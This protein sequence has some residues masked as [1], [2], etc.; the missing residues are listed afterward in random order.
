MPNHPADGSSG[1]RDAG[2]DP[3]AVLGKLVSIAS[4]QTAIQLDAFSA[5]LLG[6][7]AGFADRPPS[8]A[9]R[10][11]CGRAARHLGGSRMTFH[12]L[13]ASCLNEL[14]AQECDLSARRQQ[15]GPECNA[16]DLSLVTFEAMEQ[17]VLIDNLGH[18]LAAANAEALD[19]LS[20][21]ISHLMQRQDASLALNPFRP[22]VFLEAV[23]D[24]WTRFDLNG[25]SPL[26]I[27][28]QMR[29]EIFLD[30]EPILRALNSAL[31]GQGILPTLS[32]AYRLKKSE[33]A[34]AKAAAS[35]RRHLPLYSKLNNWLS[36]AGAGAAHPG[37]GNG[38][39]AVHPGL[40][41]LLDR[42]QKQA[43]A[44]GS[45]MQARAA[46]A[47]ILRQVREQALPGTL[48]QADANALDLLAKTLDHIFRE[49]CIPAEVKLLMSRLQIPLLK[50]ALS[51]RDFFFQEDHPARR[52]IDTVARTSVACDREQGS[53]D[54]LFRMI[55]Q[56]VER[57][58]QEYDRQ[59]G[60][61]DAVI[62]E[63][64]S[65][66][67]Q[68]A[69]ASGDALAGIIAEATRHEKIIRAKE[70]AEKDVA[71]RIESGEAAGF[72][73]A[74]LETQW[75]RVLGLAHS[76]EDT[77][78]EALANAL[79]T[80]DDLVWSAQPKAAP[81]ERKELLGRLPSL[82]ARLNSWLNVVKWEGPDRVKFFS[83]LAERHA[84]IVRT[85]AQ[86]S[87][88]AQLEITMNVAQKASER[89]LRK[90]A[91]ELPEQA[92]DEFVHYVDGLETG[93]WIE[94]ARNHGAREKSRLA[95][96]S[97]RRSRFAFT[98]RQGLEPFALTFDELA[99]AFRQQ[100]A[101]VV[102]A[103]AVVD[104][105]LAAALDEVAGG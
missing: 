31:I 2:P 63:L 14:L 32:D 16:I 37:N 66:I 74:F 90:H 43:S 8:S 56:L 44:A 94:F 82:L 91:A 12:R 55:E 96:I 99:Q 4:E 10:E 53:R 84:A 51:D 15:S 47:S 11:A 34:L 20:L 98:S 58:E 23:S 49:P 40:S 71:L 35:D 61:F 103:E 72:I 76:V 78:P 105:A 42:L 81:E 68:E 64:E 33:A 95:W 30:L 67:A 22:A 86:L 18:A 89:G 65:F 54:P 60:L 1:K 79:R 102:A 70:L 27:L 83:T 9:D 52:L 6:A 59:I 46:D 87:P 25:A 62:D 104:R 97:P 101:S 88:R 3:A 50:A 77:K 39:G 26:A 93:A 19:G 24:A 45:I 75:L 7:L 28:R 21:R 57:V 85:A 17:K 80:M 41:L 73:E 29:P 69:E 13:F 38:S 100:R 5:R 36:P 92:V 48:T